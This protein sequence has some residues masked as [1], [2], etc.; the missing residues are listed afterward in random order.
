[1][2]RQV[3]MV[4]SQGQAIVELGELLPSATAD[5]G[6]VGACLKMGCDEGDT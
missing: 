1:M 2:I 5:C 4:T 6:S 3:Q